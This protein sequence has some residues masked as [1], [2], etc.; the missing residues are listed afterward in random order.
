MPA[1]RRWKCVEWKEVW[2]PALGKY[3]RRCARFAIA[4]VPELGDAGLGQPKGQKCVRWKYVWSP[5]LGKYVRRCAEFEGVSGEMG[6]VYVPLRA[7]AAARPR[8][9]RLRGGLG[10]AVQ[11]RQCAKTKLGVYYC[12]IPGRGVKFVGKTPLPGYQVVG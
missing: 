9:P 4:G 8:P 3:V 2:S 10:I 1:G 11:P 5:A 12:W 6:E 7:R